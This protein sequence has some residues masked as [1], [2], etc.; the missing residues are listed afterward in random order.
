MNTLTRG[1]ICRGRGIHLQ[2]PPRASSSG[3]RP[4]QAAKASAT[5]HSMISTRS[6]RAAN[7]SASAPDSEL[8]PTPPLP[9]TKRI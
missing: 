7:V 6:P 5:V 2:S 1:A 8:R 4:N 3:G 9:I